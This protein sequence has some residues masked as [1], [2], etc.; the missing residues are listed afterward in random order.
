MAKA[1]R[2]KVE[3]PQLPPSHLI[4][5][6]ELGLREISFQNKAVEVQIAPG[7]TRREW[8]PQD[9]IG[10]DGKTV[11]IYRLANDGNYSIDGWEPWHDGMWG[12]RREN[13]HNALA[14]VERAKAVRAGTAK[15]F[16]GA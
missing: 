14:W 15:D 16:L 5:A 13:I 11:I 2:R 4:R 6:Q 10:L 3:T 7:E 12:G 8:L 1:R 9:L